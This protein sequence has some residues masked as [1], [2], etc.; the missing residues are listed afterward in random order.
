[1]TSVPMR[2]SRLSR[3]KSFAELISPA[4]LTGG[5]TAPEPWPRPRA[6]DPV[7]RPSPP[8]PVPSPSSAAP[9]ALSSPVPATGG[10]C[11]GFTTIFAA[12][13]AVS[14]GSAL[15]PGGAAAPSSSGV[16]SEGGGSGDGGA[17]SG[18]GWMGIA[19]V[20]VSPST[21]E[22]AISGVKARTRK[23]PKA[24][25]RSATSAN[26]PSRT[27]RAGWRSTVVIAHAPLQQFYAGGGFDKSF[28]TVHS[29]L[30][31]NIR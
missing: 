1:M 13:A 30:R 18:G 16:A 23:S 15:R 29:I 3:G 26:T 28:D 14:R 20:R 22:V 31:T 11:V 19:K 4:I 24:R 8:A 6:P 10:A 9:A 2:R 12:G 5:L 17:G 27:G 21:T 25:C 7:P